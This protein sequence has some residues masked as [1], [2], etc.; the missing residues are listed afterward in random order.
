MKQI[1]VVVLSAALAAPALAQGPAAQSAPANSARP[2]Y[3]AAKRFI[4]RAAEQVSE[5]D[6]AFKPTPEVRSFGQ[7]I[8]HVANAN[9]MICAVALGEQSPS[10]ENIE[11]ARTTKTALVDAVKASFTYCDRAYGMG[12]AELIAQ[13]ANLFGQQMS[14]LAVLSFN[15]A[16]DYEHYGNIVTYMRLKGMTPPSSAGGN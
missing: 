5:A 2:A 13:S 16:H 9:Y 12:D 6:Y 10:R 14:R 11:Q 4:V 1:M 3:E 15:A 7:L 8:G